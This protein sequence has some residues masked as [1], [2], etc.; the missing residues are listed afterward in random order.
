[1]EFIASVDTSKLYR[2]IGQSPKSDIQIRCCYLKIKN[3]NFT[4]HA[5]TAE[6][7][8]KIFKFSYKHIP[9]ARNKNFDLFQC[10]L[11]EKFSFP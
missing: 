6:I 10:K 5:D 11:V 9:L 2:K 1:M 3:T 8:I 7:I 4:A